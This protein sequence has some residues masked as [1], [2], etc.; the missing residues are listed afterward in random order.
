MSES[1]PA[2]FASVEQ[3]RDYW[4]EQAT[5]YQQ[6]YFSVV[7]FF[8]QTDIIYNGHKVTLGKGRQVCC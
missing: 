2:T 8:I 1:E 4:K 3:E 7:V 5:K 6:R